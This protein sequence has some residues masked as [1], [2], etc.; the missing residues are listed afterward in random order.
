[1]LNSLSTKLGEGRFLG[2]GSYLL[3]H[4]PIHIESEDLP[5]DAIDYTLTKNK[6]QLG[7]VS[8]G[9]RQA[10]I[11][12]RR[13]Q[14]RI[15]EL[16]L[17]N[18]SYQCA[19]CDIA[20]RQLLVTSHISRWADDPEAR[21]N[22]SNVICFCRFHDPLFEYGYL[23]LSN[24]YQV[25]KKGIASQTASPISLIL[26]HTY[27]FRLPRSNPPAAEFLRKHRLRTGFE[28]WT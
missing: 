7:I 5:D 24:S 16:V 3:L 17:K 1:M 19:F 21:G 15:R 10:M 23:S 18:Y 12:Q 28:A 26:N 9:D 14:D 13:G 6:L 8:T 2:E 11:R 22:L 4:S 25:L 20:D 27:K